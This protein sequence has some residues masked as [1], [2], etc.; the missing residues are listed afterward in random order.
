MKKRRC[1]REVGGD[2]SAGRITFGVYAS[3][4]YAG[5]DLAPSTM[6]N[7][8]RHLEEHL[9]PEFEGSALADI[10]ARDVDAWERKERERGYAAASI[11]TWRGTL[12]LVL[13]DA[14]EMD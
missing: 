4:W 2:P 13:S 14:V 6:Q 9:L 11:S 5:Q 1:V 3:R 7:Y 8:R 12:H 10:F